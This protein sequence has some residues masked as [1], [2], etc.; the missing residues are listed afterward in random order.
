MESPEPNILAACASGEISP[1][2]AFD[3]L[4]VL[5]EASVFAWLAARVGAAA[6]ADLSQDTWAVFHRRWRIWNF[7]PEMS[8]AE[9]RPVL[10]FL[11]RSCHLI[12]SAHRRLQARVILHSL[13]DVEEPAG[14]HE[15]DLRHHAL[16]FQRCLETARQCCPEEEFDVLL[17]KLAEVPAREI[18]RSL[19]VSEAIV[20]HRFRN[21]IAR[22]R[23]ALG[24]DQDG[25]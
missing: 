12:V 6:A 24:T 16:E 4:Y 1:D 9:A 21:A 15:I 8:T 19:G 20:D 5:Y 17:A 23:R 14:P 10:S 13:T 2:Q 25:L 3:R 7:L 22:V 11:Y 18:A